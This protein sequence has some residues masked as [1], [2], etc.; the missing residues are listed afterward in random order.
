MVKNYQ[1]YLSGTA[2]IQGTGGIV[3]PKT[4]LKRV[5]TVTLFVISRLVILHDSHTWHINAHVMV[6][7]NHKLLHP[8]LCY[9]G[10]G[11]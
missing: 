6:D 4:L 2:C 1:S 9:R 11:S 10:Q 8:D 7:E 5:G 3:I